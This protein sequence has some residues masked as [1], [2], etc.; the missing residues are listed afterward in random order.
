MNPRGY[1]GSAEDR[2][3]LGEILGEAVQGDVIDEVFARFCLG[4]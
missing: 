1:S 4:K 3:S 2:E